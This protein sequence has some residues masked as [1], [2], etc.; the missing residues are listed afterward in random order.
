MVRTFNVAFNT[1]PTAVITSPQASAT[2]PAAVTALNI[3]ASDP[4]VVVLPTNGKVA[5]LGATTAPG[6]GDAFLVYNWSFGSGAS[7][8][9]SNLASPGEV[10][11]SGQPGQVISYLVE[12]TVTDIFGRVSKNAPGGV[13]T[14]TFRRWVVV[15]GRDSQTFTMSFLYRQR[16]P[17][18]GGD[19]YAYAQLPSHGNAA[20]VTI[21][22]D[23]ITNTYAVTGASGA[24][25]A[26]PVR[27]DVPFWV[28]IPAI[29]GDTGDTSA[30][31]FRIPNLPGIDPDLELAGGPKPLHPSDGTAFAFMNPAGPYNPQLQIATGSGF[32][33]EVLEPPQRKLQGHTD[34]FNNLCGASGTNVVEPNLRWL[35]RLSAPT[36]DATVHSMPVLISNFPAYIYGFNGIAGYQSFPEWFVF[37]K[38]NEVV[39]FNTLG[40]SGSQIGS[41]H[42]ASAPTD[43]GF[44]MDGKYN[45][46]TQTS[47]HFA[48]SAIQAYRA[49][50]SQLDPYDFDVM[51]NNISVPGSTLLQDAN[52]D[53]S[54]GLNPTPVDAAGLSFMS[55]LVNTAPSAA[56]LVGGILNVAIPYDANNQDRV[57]NLSKHY[58]AFGYNSTF[59]YAEYLWTKVWQRPL[60]L[61]RTNLSWADTA[62]GFSNYPR[63]QTFPMECTATNQTQT[64]DLPWFFYSNPSSGW[65]KAANVSPNASAYDL[66]VSG[67]GTFDAS[68]PVTE[69]AN[70]GTTTGVG[71]FFWTAF[72]PNY[73]ANTGALI[74][75]TWLA[76][77][78][79]KQI[80]TTF[81]GVTGDATTVGDVTTAW[82]FVPPQDAQIDKRAR[83]LDGTPVANSL[84]GYRVQWFNPSK[85][86][87]GHPVPP[88]F[89]AIQVLAGGVTNL[90]LVSGNY[91]RVPQA[92]TDSLMTDA[93]TF[94]P[95]GQS[96]YQTG[97]LAG[98]GYCWFD[99]PPEVRPQ[100]GSAI[101]TVFAL[102]SIL[103][104]NA[105]SG[106][107]AIN[108][109]EW[110]EA[111][112]TVTASISTKPSG[113]DVSF[114][115][116]IPFNYP[117][118]IVVVNGPATPV[119]P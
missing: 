64:V 117:W 74:S 50:V 88:D 38:S 15:D 80:P 45:A 54:A 34:L 35:D 81:T 29:A 62:I 13:G 115:H 113:V 24:T 18:T 110:V 86:A 58:N 96:T 108:R 43:L 49:P 44:V 72:N 53:P 60:V 77:G 23:G 6:S 36:T 61:N 5:F 57:P 8:S 19:S 70:V 73:N 105:V 118:D 48:T 116:K 14:K 109:T 11:F 27:S 63:S 107:R 95:S 59:G 31:Q 82:G 67:G 87:V 66:T 22:Q 56:P 83:N 114:A 39:D 85:D 1:Y 21:F 3:P 17:V 68:S 101:V 25:T 7:P 69:D 46:L 41:Y 103:R 30:Y 93:R 75:R 42:G 4:D 47:E 102:K 89:W 32:G 16:S 52:L 2:I 98:P 91:P 26:I 111:V 28:N 99:I 33:T 104:N 9:S 97:D 65:P 12:F 10:V 40:V 84:G 92:M 90:Y 100:A 78:S 55:G 106:A 71:R 20:S 51:K 94:L 76:D 79:R 37:L 119:A 112:K